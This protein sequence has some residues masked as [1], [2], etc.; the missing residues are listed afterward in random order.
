MLLEAVTCDRMPMAAE[1][2][3]KR[4]ARAMDAAGMS[5]EELGRQL[6]L[7]NGRLVRKWKNEG[8]VPRL[9]R[10]REIARILRCP[11]EDLI[12]DEGMPQPAN[13]RI[14]NHAKHFAWWLNYFIER[15]GIV[16]SSLAE[17][18]GISKHE[19]S[20]Y[21]SGA[22]YPGLHTAKQLAIALGVPLDTLLSPPPPGAVPDEAEEALE[23]LEGH[24]RRT[25]TRGR[26]ARRRPGTD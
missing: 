19:L 2:F 3:G 26:A 8:V 25:P 24:P 9:S 15:D 7:R 6:G 22:A 16:A 13:R 4:L 10:I 21:R 1:G 18:A 12:P 11:V 14:P 23:A 20:R 17:R 5:A